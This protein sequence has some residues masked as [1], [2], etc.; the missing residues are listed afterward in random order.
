MA[1]KRMKK[2]LHTSCEDA[3]TY[4]GVTSDDAWLVAANCMRPCEFYTA[5]G[6]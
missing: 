6:K 4:L 3:P 1:G 5:Q 2:I